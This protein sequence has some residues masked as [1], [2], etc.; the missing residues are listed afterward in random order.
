MAVTSKEGA[1]TESMLAI[2]MGIIVVVFGAAIW[3]VSSNRE[4]VI[5]WFEEHHFPDWMHHKH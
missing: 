5:R 1:M 3:A 4:Q 2:L